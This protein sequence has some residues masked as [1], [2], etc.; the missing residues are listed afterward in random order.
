MLQ[1][2]ELRSVRHELA[3]EQKQQPFFKNVKETGYFNV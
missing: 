1:C 3:T 2:V